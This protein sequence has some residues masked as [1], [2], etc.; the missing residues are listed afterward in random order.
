MNL[1]HPR[2]KRLRGIR[3]F[4]LLVALAESV[5]LLIAWVTKAYSPA[6]HVDCVPRVIGGIQYVCKQPSV[7]LPAQ[8]DLGGL[9]AGA[10][11]VIVEIAIVVGVSLLIVAAVD[12]AMS[13]LFSRRPAAGPV[14]RAD[15]DLAAEHPES[16]ARLEE[17]TGPRP[18]ALA[19]PKPW[20]LFLAVGVAA[21]WALLSV[22]P[23]SLAKDFDQLIPMD[24]TATPLCPLDLSTGTPR[25]QSDWRPFLPSLAG[26][27]P[28]CPYIKVAEPNIDQVAFLEADGMCHA[29]FGGSVDGLVSDALIAAQNGAL[30]FLVAGAALL[31]WPRLRAGGVGPPQT[32]SD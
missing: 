11:S 1:L 26:G 17:T 29:R 14:L 16:P 6:L 12:Q 3:R 23:G 25:C 10:P 28:G 24:R 31:L 32:L 27:D 7:D 4:A 20:F 2:M 5:F 9:V 30:A 15:I 22:G 21:A 19:R 8:F 13:R 18:L